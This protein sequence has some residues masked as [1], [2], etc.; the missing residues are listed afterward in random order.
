M[1]MGATKADF[2][3]LIGIH[4]TAAENF[5]TLDVTTASGE[6]L[7]PEM[8]FITDGCRIRMPEDADLKHRSHRVLYCDCGAQLCSDNLLLFSCV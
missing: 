7:I 5:T 8:L 1:K 4:P 3:K 2:D 6:V